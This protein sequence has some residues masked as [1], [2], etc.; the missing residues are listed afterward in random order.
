MQEQTTTPSRRAFLTG[1]GS[2]GITSLFAGCSTVD[3]G[4]TFEAKAATVPQTVLEQ[5]GY[6]EETVVPQS[7]Q[8]SFG[9]SGITQTVVV[10]NWQAEYSKTLSLPGIDLTGH[11]PLALFSILATPRVDILGR[12]F[13]PIGNWS[14]EEIAAE[15]Q[16]QYH[17][18]DGLEPH[19][20]S[21][22]EILGQPT[23]VTRFRG[24]GQ[25]GLPTDIELTIHIS[26]AVEAGD[27]FV[28]A[29]GGYPATVADTEEQ[30]VRTLLESIQHG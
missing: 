13:N 7:I 15:V 12:S 30:N 8:Q 24:D 10:T 21:T 18:L 2:V 1:V 16:A 6:R 9:V 27:D 25:F 29:L 11:Q 26:E 23:T 17:G 19:G 3:N 20:S 28:V 5:T 22:I 14:V 4:L